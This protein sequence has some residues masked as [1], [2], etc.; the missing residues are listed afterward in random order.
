MTAISHF[1]ELHMNY[2]S[3]LSLM[4]SNLRSKLTRVW[5]CQKGLSPHPE[6]LVLP[7]VD[8]PDCDWLQSTIQKGNYSSHS[9]L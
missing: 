8:F 2:F 4:E 3:S 1:W 6:T 7:M 9:A 5:S